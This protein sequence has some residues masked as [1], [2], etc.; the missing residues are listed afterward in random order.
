MQFDVTQFQKNGFV[1]MGIVHKGETLVFST[2]TFGKV[3]LPNQEKVFDGINAYFKTLS[4]D[5][6]DHIFMTYKNIR[7]IL[8]E[9][10]DM[11]QVIRYLRAYVNELYERM[12]LDGICKWL[13]TYGNLYI[14]A[15]PE[16]YDVLP[17]DSVYNTRR[18]REQTYLKA[19][20][21][22]LA[23]LAMAVRP[24]IPIWGEFID[25]GGYGIGAIDQKE[26][27]AVSLIT[28]TELIY[29]PSV[30]EDTSDEAELDSAFGKLHRHISLTTSD[31]EFEPNNIWRGRNSEDVP[32]QAHAKV[33]VRRLTIM[34]LTDHAS[35]HNIVANIYQYVKNNLKSSD[36]KPSDQIKNKRDETYQRDEDDK[37]SFIEDY[38]TKVRISKGD[39]ALLNK[40]SREIETIARTVDPT[41]DPA[42]LNICLGMID[43]LY[44]ERPYGHQIELAQWVLAK[45]FSPKA[46]GHIRK[47]NLVRLFA[48]AQ[49]LLWHWGYVDLA[50]L[51]TVRQINVTDEQTPYI[52]AHTRTNT[53]ILGKFADDLA[54]YYPHNKP[55]R[56]SKNS[57]G[58]G[59]NFASANI[60][61]LTKTILG[62]N[63]KYVGVK[64]L[65]KESGQPAGR[66]I[67]VVPPTIKNRLSELAIHL[68]Q[69]NTVS[70][71]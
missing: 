23:T 18:Q 53:R 24:L 14:P 20:Y 43:K 33:L 30:P 65:L 57:D 16:V 12:P 58:K 69:I 68:A 40:A 45:G 31:Q 15:P 48:C 1:E 3:N 67:L 4:E 19:D 25:Q 63:W 44:K 64:E 21:I 9:T 66:N 5:D 47:S 54:Q 22:N 8:T 2:S 60:T 56:V 29:W 34:D 71:L 7:E 37:S 49:A 26:L 6:Q 27:E 17:E 28:D 36:R 11:L 42:K 52:T 70:K 10:I 32:T 59:V 55:Q 41:Y 35:G 50:T 62:G 38:K 51:M 46:F 39:I 61:N 13:L